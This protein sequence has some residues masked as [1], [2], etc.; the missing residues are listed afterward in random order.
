MNINFEL[1]RIFYVV[2]LNKNMSRAS[3]E[4]YISQPAV[5][6]SIKK[7]E[8]Q[9]GA[10][11]F[12]RS[13][14]GLELTKEGQNFF[15]Y[16]KGAIDLIKSGENEFENFKQL[17][18]GEV[19]IGASTTLT[20]LI[21]IDAIK[22]FKKDFPNIKI[23]II[24]DLTQN[25]ILDLKKG[26]LD[27]VV[28]NENEVLE[29]GVKLTLLKQLDYA[30]VYNKNNYK[31]NND[32]SLKELNN[33]PLILQKPKSHTRKLLDDFCLNNSVQLKPE[34]EVV[35]GELVK[36]LAKNGLGI[37]FILKALIEDD[38]LQEITLK[39]KL[40]K[41]QVYLSTHK[42]IALTFASKKF[43]KYLK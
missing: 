8:E 30:F 25:L 3:E 39:E 20:K 15:D 21:L 35:S 19:R 7:L 33:Y 41:A 23:S 27:L 38:I 10:S 17:K 18:F 9:L 11:L 22:N 14:K 43:I 6:Q 29:D 34:F 26:N 40:P 28:Y 5:S 1:Y 24:N 4:L 32:L 16:I 42:N 12:V 31:F 37:G 36:D 2:A 13:N